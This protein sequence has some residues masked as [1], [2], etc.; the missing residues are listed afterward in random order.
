VLIALVALWTQLK[1]LNDSLTI[2]QLSDYTK[3]YQE[4]ILNFPEDINEQEFDLNTRSDYN[5][6]MRYMRA[7]IDLCFEEWYLHQR[8]LIDKQTWK[9]WEEGIRASFTKPAFRDAWLTIRDDTSFRTQF[10]QFLNSL[11]EETSSRK[12]LKRKP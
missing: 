12:Q 11:T 10:E 7:Y 3:R 4:I 6:T 9:S 8:G 5:H 2:Q 1:K